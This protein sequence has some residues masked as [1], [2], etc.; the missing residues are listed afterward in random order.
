MGLRWNVSYPETIVLF[1]VVFIL[2]FLLSPLNTLAKKKG[3][4][5]K[6]LLP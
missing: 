4:L 6:W 2:S 3:V 1:I 5:F